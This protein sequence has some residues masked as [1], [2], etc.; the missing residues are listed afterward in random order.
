MLAAEHGKSNI[1]RILLA[2]GANLEHV[3][4]AGRTALS[5]AALAW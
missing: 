4:I 2:A 1:M 5:M 3:N